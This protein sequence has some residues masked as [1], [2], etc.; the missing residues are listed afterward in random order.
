MVIAR[1]VVAAIGHDEKSPRSLEGVGGG[2]IGW[3]S[4]LRRCSPWTF[5]LM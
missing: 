3:E 4:R 2:G 5:T 1:M